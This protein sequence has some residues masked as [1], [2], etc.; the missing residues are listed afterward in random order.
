MERERLRRAVEL[1]AAGKWQEAHGIVQQDEDDALACWAHGIVHLLEGDD[2]NAGYWYRRAGR[3]MPA[4]PNH[5]E[6]IGALR[7]TLQRAG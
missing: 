6:E 2:G 1:L 5:G 7:E 3:A 4:A